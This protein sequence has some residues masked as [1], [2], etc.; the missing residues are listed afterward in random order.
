[1]A[2][3]PP[4]PALTNAITLL[5]N[6]LTQ[7]QAHLPAGG[8]ATTPVL[9]LFD[10]STP[11]DMASRAGSTAMTHASAALSAKWDGSILKLPA[12]LAALKKRA[13][14]A[15]WYA[16]A[17]NGILHFP[18]HDLLSEYD[19]VDVLDIA[20]AFTLRTDARA[21]QNSLAMFQCLSSSFEGDLQVIF[22]QDSNLPSNEDGPTLFKM[23]TELTVAAASVLSLSALDD[24]HHLEP[25]D[26]RFNLPAINSRIT[27]LF[28]L[29]TTSSRKIPDAERVQIIIRIYRRIRQ[30]LSWCTWVANKSEAFDSRSLPGPA[31]A[32]H[33]VLMNNAVL[34]SVKISNDKDFPITWK[35]TTVEQDVV[36]MM[37]SPPPPPAPSSG[38]P[39][40]TP[41]APSRRSGGRPARSNATPL[42][43]FARH[44]RVSG[45][46]NARLHTVG[47][48]KTHEGTTW[49]FCDCPNHRNG[50][51]WHTYPAADCR[52]RATW[53][54]AGSPNPPTPAGNVADD[55]TVSTAATPPT[56]IAPPNGG[57]SNSSPASVAFLAQALSQPDLTDSTRDL[58]AGALNSFHG[59]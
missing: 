17:P 15:K 49:N 13:H 33:I 47:D 48:T 53:L 6:I 43:P 31:N 5:G 42:P 58:I 41:S 44:A 19:A 34:H 51:K 27:S 45:D 29:A 18:P 20:S 38:N 46:V 14:E 12:F 16:P 23:M 3:N 28:T 11:F 25:A 54:A 57:T 32:K 50:V 9:T 2:A 35:S 37:A 52:L 36:A 22:D 24:L 40:S 39:A 8:Q 59:I 56:P 7:M 26:F 21:K 30:P 1:M 55:L 4:D 10:D